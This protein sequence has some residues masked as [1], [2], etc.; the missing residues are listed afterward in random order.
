MI[1]RA[2][3]SSAVL[4][5]LSAAT[6]LADLPSQ[7]GTWTLLDTMPAAEQARDAFIRANQFQPARIDLPAMQA[8]LA[9]APMERTPEAIVP[10]RITL[11]TP[12]GGFLQFDIIEYSM[13]EPGLAAQFPEIH[14]YLGQCVENPAANVHLDLTMHGFRAQVISPQGMWAIDPFSK[15]ETTYY[16]SYYAKDLD[17]PGF[18]CYTEPDPAPVNADSPYASRATGT[19]LRTYRLAMAACPSYTMPIGGVT[20]AQSAIVT[21]VNRVNQVYGNELAVRFTLVANNTSIIYTTSNPGPYTDGALNTMINQN[22]TNLNSVIGSANYDIGH[23]IS[24][25]NLG[26]LAALRALCSST[27]K[28]R[29]GTGLANVY[30]DGFW[31]QYVSHELGHQCG[32][33]HT[34]NANDSASGNVCLPNRNSSTAYEPGSGT[35]IMSYSHLCGSNNQVQTG[36]DPMFNLSSYSEIAAHI[37]GNGSCSSNAATGN[38]PP[39]VN[40]GADRSVPVGTAF[41]MTATSA[42]VN[43]DSV[44]YSWEQRDLGPSQPESGTG[45]ADNGTSPLFRVFAPTANAFR[46]FPRLSEVISG[47]VLNG[48]QYPTVARTLRLRVTARDNRAGGGGVNTDDVSVAIVSIN[49]PFQLTA[50]NTNVTWSGNETVTWTVAGTNAA[51]FN[52]ANVKISLSTNGGHLFTTLLE[53]TPNTGSAQISLP[54]I[55]S[56][57]ARI[58]I[59]AI[60]GVFFDISDVNFAISPS[61]GIPAPTDLTATPGIVCPGGSTVLSATV[62][63]GQTVDWFTQSCGGTFAGTGT[64][65]MVS[66]TVG[67]IYRAQARVLSSGETSTNCGNIFVSIGV[68]PSITTSPSN[69]SIIEGDPV[70]FSVTATG[71]VPLAY[72]WRLNG[73]PVTNGGPILGANTDTLTISPA[74]LADAGTYDVLV[75]NSCGSAPSAPALLSVTPNCGTSDFNGDGDFG[76]DADIESFFACLGGSCCPACFVGGADFNADGDVGTDA[77]IE[78]FFRVLGGGNC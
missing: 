17:N 37:S 40:G 74:T 19:T 61:F 57:L 73:S 49:G 3:L 35:T 8:R 5:S 2:F 26:G 38:T 76:T 23:V 45:S 9:L 1:R 42:D 25:Q 13:M 78:A 20:Q 33:N 53:S 22:Q 18:S 67:T 4:C 63:E 39:T 66:P 70:T 32:A 6:A 48:E 65:L 72:Q 24:G 36:P 34:F 46:T 55:T 71:S 11:P 56:T 47:A 62:P 64:S 12:D 41:T 60:G 54:P 68:A 77:D 44:T 16:T 15:N 51:P 28:A 59:E 58:K 10:A 75:S 31:V 52:V 29:G 30:G 21:G 14:T 69:E 27:N 50:P 43:N 7:D